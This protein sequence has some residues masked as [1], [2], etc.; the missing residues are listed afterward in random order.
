MPQ[1][2]AIIRT[3]LAAVALALAAGTA[4]AQQDVTPVTLSDIRGMRF[5]E[6]LLIFDDHI[7]IYNTSNAQGCPAEEWRALDPAAIAANHGAQGRAAEWP[8]FLGHG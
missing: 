1:D 6:F 4:A 5:C 2:H 8:A 7:D 3:T